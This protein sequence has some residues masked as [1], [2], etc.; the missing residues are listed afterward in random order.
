[1]HLLFIDIFNNAYTTVVKDQSPFLKMSEEEI[2]IYIG[3]V[4]SKYAEQVK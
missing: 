1:M 2:A 3:T 4:L